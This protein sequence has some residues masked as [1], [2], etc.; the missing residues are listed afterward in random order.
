[1]SSYHHIDPYNY[2][3]TA[4]RPSYI[5]HGNHHTWKHSIHIET[6]PNGNTHHVD[7]TY[8]CILKHV[9]EFSNL[10]FQNNSVSNK[11]CLAA[12]SSSTALKEH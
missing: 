2:D 4:W 9:F 12:T 5:Q 10:I 1:M 7:E 6:G 3:K 11:V 8:E